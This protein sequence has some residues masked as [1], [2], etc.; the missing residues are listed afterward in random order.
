MRRSSGP[1]FIRGFDP[2]S[3]KIILDALSLVKS[4]IEKYMAE[5]KMAVDKAHHDVIDREIGLEVRRIKMV[6]N[7]LK[8]GIRD[9]GFMSTESYEAIMGIIRSALE[10]YLQDTLKAKAKSGLDAFDDKIAEIRQITIFAGLKDGKTDLYDKYFEAP[11]TSP[12][13]KKVEVFFSYSNKDRVL[14]GKIASLLT[15]KGIDVFLAH[16]DIKVSKQ[17]REEIFKHIESDNVLLALL[18]PN[19]E[20]SVWANQEAGIMRG[21]GGKVIPLIVEGIKLKNFGF[22][23]ALQGIKVSQKLDDCVQEIL[24]IIFR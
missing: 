2:K 3:S 9:G 1:R 11:I 15:E 17:W 4:R 6:D 5:K 13:G 22:L 21:K 20:K 7:L 24:S 14:A 16:E 18:T 19:Y 10:V 23:E 12:K 8:E